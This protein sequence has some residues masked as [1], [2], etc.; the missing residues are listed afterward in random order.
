LILFLPV[1][2]IIVW[3]EHMRKNAS[4]AR[5]EEALNQ[6]LVGIA[7]ERQAREA[8]M[9]PIADIQRQRLEILRE[10]AKPQNVCSLNGIGQ[11]GNI[12]ADFVGGSG[13]IYKINLFHLSCTCPD[14]TKHR[15]GFDRTD[16]RRICKHLCQQLRIER[17]PLDSLFSVM[18][19]R[20]AEIGGVPH[21]LH[22]VDLT[23]KAKILFGKSNTA[24]GYSVYSKRINAS[25]E[26][27]FH[28]RVDYHYF[29]LDSRGEKWEWLRNERP[30]GLSRDIRTLILDLEKRKTEIKVLESEK[31][32]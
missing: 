28:G 32:P 7:A 1:V 2:G 4:K 17:V 26:Y 3:L 11:D 15:S 19:G 12:D 24:R 6:L 21:D 5:R 29:L 22:Y 18:L 8:A 9:P 16:M 31:V 13:T 27:E 30:V 25:G 20:G 23:G 14:W 10:Q